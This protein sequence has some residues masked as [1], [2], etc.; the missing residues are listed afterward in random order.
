[1]LGCLLVEEPITLLRCVLQLDHSSSTASSKQCY[2]HPTLFFFNV[3]QAARQHFKL[4]STNFPLN[5]VSPLTSPFSLRRSGSYIGSPKNLDPFNVSFQCS[6][7]QWNRCSELEE[8]RVTTSACN[9][10]TNP[11]HSCADTWLHKF[12]FFSS[13]L[14]SF[15]FFFSCTVSLSLIYHYIYFFIILLLYIFFLYIFIIYISFISLIFI[16]YFD[17]F[18][19]I[20]ITN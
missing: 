1:M 3:S 4:L 13:L 16:S 15:F 6:V 10:C 2:Q 8:E 7:Y 9:D 19:K 12:L 18:S 14:P 17:F 5:F 20:L 11:L